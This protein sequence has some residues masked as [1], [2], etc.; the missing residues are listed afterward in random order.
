MVGLKDDNPT[1]S[2]EDPRLED[3]ANDSYAKFERKETSL[4]ESTPLRA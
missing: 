4:K 1:T 3:K 2:K